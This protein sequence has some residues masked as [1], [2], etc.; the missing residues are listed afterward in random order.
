MFNK[1]LLNHLKTSNKRQIA[2]KIMYSVVMTFT[3][4]ALLITPI[5]SSLIRYKLYHSNAYWY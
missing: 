3:F 2:L 5:L 4:L 1:L